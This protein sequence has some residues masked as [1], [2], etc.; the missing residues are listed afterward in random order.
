MHLTDLCHN[1]IPVP[2]D[3]GAVPVYG[4]A[5]DSRKVGVGDV[6]FAVAGS[7]SDGRDY[8]A[9]AVKAGAVAVITDD[10]PFNDGPVDNE[11]HDMGSVGIPVL[12]SSNPRQVM[13]LMAARFWPAQPGM[14]AAVTGT[15]GKTSTAE[16]LRQL[17]Q[18]VSWRAVA[19]GT[20]GVTGTDKLNVNGALLGLPSLTTPDSLSL[21]AT[22]NALTEAGM[23]HLAL[24]ASSHGLEQHRLDGLSLHVAAFTNLS[25][26]HLDHHTDMDSYFAAKLRLFT[27]LLKPGGHAV[28]NI[29]DPHSQ[30]IIS[31]LDGREIVITTYGADKTADFCIES[32]TPAGDGLTMQVTHLGQ[33]WHIP[34][35]LSGTFQAMNALAAA[36]MAHASGLPLHDSLGGLPYLSAAPGRMQTVYGHPTGA[37]VIVDYAH[38]P[39]ALDAALTALRPETRG[40][41]IVLFGCGGDRDAGKRA[42]M[43]AVAATAADHVIITDDNPRREDPAAIRAAIAAACPNAEEIAPRDTAIHR[44]IDML[45]A[46]DVLLIAGKGHESVQLIGTETLP[47]DDAAVAANAIAA[48]K[49]GTA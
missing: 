9:D 41:L 39:D 49:G 40:R 16:F 33:S 29:D 45:Q 18:R 46:G 27:A 24:E 21:H 5:V 19:M 35:A 1:L 36:V 13:A 47:F 11:P 31:A 48:L 10:R 44:A 22:I 8:I 15:N 37:R 4:L 25:R 34:L 12:Y 32:I 28:I 3:A 26:D 7:H 14:V 38:T 17:W 30:Q 2:A 43:G 23:T 42:L 20:L 6:F